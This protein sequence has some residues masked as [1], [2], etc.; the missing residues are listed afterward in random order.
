[1][2][3]NIGGQ[4]AFTVKDSYIRRASAD[5]VRDYYLIAL[6]E[7]REERRGYPNRTG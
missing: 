3:S 7:V 4:V 5:F 6:G 2:L 1:L